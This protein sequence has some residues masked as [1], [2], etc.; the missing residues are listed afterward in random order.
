[1]NEFAS[2]AGQQ[3]VMVYRRGADGVGVAVEEDSTLLV[4][5]D[6]VDIKFG[7]KTPADIRLI[8]S[9]GI[10]VDNSSLTGEPDHLPRQPGNAEEGSRIDEAG[11]M[12]F[13]TTKIME[14]KGK[15]LV[16]AIGDRTFMGMVAGLTLDTDAEDTPIKKEIHNFIHIVSGIAMFLGI[17]FFII[18]MIKAGELSIDSFV[19]NLVFM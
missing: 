6:V 10:K 16:T 19:R 14:G 4:A 8:D 17:T 13:Y 1:M 9:N 2:L 15:G 3:K 5:G 18:G 12:C 7:D 11:N